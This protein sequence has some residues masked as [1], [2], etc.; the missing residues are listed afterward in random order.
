MA[1]SRMSVVPRLAIAIDAVSSAAVLAPH[2]TFTIARLSSSHGFAH[3]HDHLRRSIMRM[4]KMRQKMTIII[5][6][7]PKPPHRSPHKFVNVMA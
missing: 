7:S 2:P 3:S 4:M 6:I 5:S 1:S